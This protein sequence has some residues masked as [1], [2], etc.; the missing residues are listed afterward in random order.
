MSS[1]IFGMFNQP[2]ETKEEPLQWKCPAD[3]DPLQIDEEVE[4]VADT[5]IKKFMI[6]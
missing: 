2:K 3:A 6:H 4:P 5:C 1:K